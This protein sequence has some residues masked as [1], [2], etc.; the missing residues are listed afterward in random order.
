M[1]QPDPL[2]VIADIHGNALALR[3]VLD[4]IAGLGITRIVNLGDVFS[5]PMDPA[6]VWDLLRGRDI[7]T[8]RGNH[9]RYLIDMAPGD[10]GATDR[11]THGLLP[12]A[13]RDWIRT[14]P[15]ELTWD[16]IY[17]CH[18]TPQDDNT[19]WTEEVLNGA[20]RLAP[21]SMIEA[22]AEGIDAGLI[23][24]AHTHLPRVLELSG[25]RLLV[26]PG[27][28][29]CPGYTDDAPTPHVVQTGTPRASYAVV[30][31]EGAGWSVFH[32]HVNYDWA[33]AARQARGHG[34]EDWARVVGTGWLD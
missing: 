25:G 32:R 20:P 26:N 6:G 23:L 5:G 21:G 7:P 33:A 22:R 16:G 19:Y 29:G 15:V 14:L 34:R 11:L 27:S 10:M 31:R 18:A 3:A 9:D 1:S 17:A 12:E 13:A 4:D 30:Q 24:F 28:V 8:V 2:A